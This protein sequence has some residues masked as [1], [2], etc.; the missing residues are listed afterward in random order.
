MPEKWTGELI[1]QM[2]LAKVTAKQLSEYMGVSETWVSGILN[3]KRQCKHAK[4]KFCA[5]F[6]EMVA[7]KEK[8]EQ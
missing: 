8:E 4:E 3:G 2:H 6:S 1:C 7:Q 5:A